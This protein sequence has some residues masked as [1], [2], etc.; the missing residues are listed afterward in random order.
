MYEKREREKRNIDSLL[1]LYDF[2]FVFVLYYFYFHFMIYFYGL[3]I[4]IYILYH[5]CPDILSK[6][7][8]VTF[9]VTI[10]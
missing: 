10:Q 9:T 6:F 3:Y 5:T 1:S 4:Y 7:L 2:V 8:S